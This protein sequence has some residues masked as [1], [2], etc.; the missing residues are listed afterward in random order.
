VEVGRWLGRAEGSAEKNRRAAKYAEEA[1]RK[2]ILR[3]GERVEIFYLSSSSLL[4]GFFCT[5]PFLFSS[6]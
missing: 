4:S 1:Q 6:L 2:T 5:R 3:R